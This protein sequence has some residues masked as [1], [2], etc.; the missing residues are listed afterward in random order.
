M[1]FFL[2]IV[3]LHCILSSTSA[4]GQSADSAAQAKAL[5]DSVNNSFT[6]QRGI[7]K[8]P[9][10]IAVI[11]V[12][13]GFK[14]VSPAESNYIL[15]AL[16]D[17]P[18]DSGSLG[19]LFPEQT[20]PLGGTW[21]IDIRYSED[22]HIKDDDAKDIDYD[23]LLSQMKEDVKE[24]SK[25]REKDGYPTI[26]L[27]SWAENPYY[28]PEA[29]KLYWAK[30]L[31]FS[32]TDTTLNFNIRVLGRKGY[33]LLNAIG[34]MEN[35]EEIKAEVPAVLAATNFSTGNQ[36]TDF[37]PSIDQ[38]AAYGIGGLIAGKVLAKAGFW[39]L[40]AKFGKFIV[41][42]AVALFASLRKQIVGFFNRS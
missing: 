35:L 40:L 25:A 15:N 2:S 42:G 9:N 14:Y 41:I 13:K 5:V 1:R 34:S 11:D 32:G 7:I 6:Y 10:G 21:A 37:D 20:F 27:L 29:K 17:N 38:V 28:D 16:W 36:Y 30:T 26:E 22:G 33:L 39:A 12:P 18:P 8:L 23:D 3:V 31:L 24:E 19:M 4:V